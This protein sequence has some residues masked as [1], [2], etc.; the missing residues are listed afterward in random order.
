LFQA[1]ETLSKKIT[2]AKKGMAQVVV[3]PNKVLSS[4]PSTEK[5]KKNKDG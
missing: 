5:R 2:K 4:N 1:K 3:L